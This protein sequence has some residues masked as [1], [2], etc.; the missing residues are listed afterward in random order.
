M[1]G[2]VP[3][4]QTEATTALLQEVP[5]EDASMKALG[6]AAQGECETAHGPWAAC[7]QPAL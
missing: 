6:S 5:R 2:A 4:A 1:W 3:E 7:A